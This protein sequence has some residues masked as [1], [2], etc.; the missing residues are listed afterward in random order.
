MSG[1]DKKYFSGDDIR[2][3]IDGTEY[4]CDD[5]NYGSGLLYYI[6]EEIPSAGWK[7]EIFL[8]EEVAGEVVVEVAY[9]N[10]L[11]QNKTFKKFFANALAYI[12]SQQNE[13]SFTQYFLGVDL[14]DDAYTVSG[15][16]LFTDEACTSGLKVDGLNPTGVDDNDDFTINNETSAQTIRCVRYRVYDENNDLLTGNSKVAA[17]SGAYEFNNKDYA[18]YFKVD[19]SSAWRVWG[20]K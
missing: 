3:E 17:A 7:A 11:K 6:N 5:E 20:N 4:T 10:G 15:F 8:E 16:Q 2:F 19:G 9:A 18:D 14:F 12:K 1:N 13:E